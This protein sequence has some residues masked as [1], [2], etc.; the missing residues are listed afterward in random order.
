MMNSI[1]GSM[2]C[3]ALAAAAIFAAGCGGNGGTT[4]QDNAYVRFIN[5]S[6]DSTALNFFIDDTRL[7]TNVAYL[8][9][10]PSFARVDAGERDATVLEQGGTQELAAI[11]I[12]LAKDE[13]NI[14]TAIGLRDFGTEN[15]KR[16]RL[17]PFGVNR[18][19]PTGNK[20]QLYIIH[21]FMKP[22]GQDT[23]N[24]DFRNPGNNPQFQLTGIAFGTTRE[25]LVDSGPQTFTARFSGGEQE[26]M[27]ETLQLAPGSIHFVVLSGI[28][29]GVGAQAPKMQLFTIPPK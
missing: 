18:T 10:S 11:V 21:A 1:K 26:Y 23:P 13:Q 6:P 20:S 19:A 16:L 22:A 24:L 2:C 29:G 27:T 7:G 25:L 9:T 15:E 28:E 17:V 14:V 4:A 12:D 5:A 8:G 3:A